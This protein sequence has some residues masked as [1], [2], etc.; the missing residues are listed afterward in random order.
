MFFTSTHLWG[1]K[2]FTYEV[3]KLVNFINL[4]SS[5]CLFNISCDKIGRML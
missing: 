4:D 3:V 2:D 5:A 1:K